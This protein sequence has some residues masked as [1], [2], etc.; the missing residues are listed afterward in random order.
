MN[1]T[2]RADCHKLPDLNPIEHIWANL[3]RAIR[4]HTTREN[5]L[6]L[7]IAMSIQGLFSR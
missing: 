7:A 6:S 1:V 4:N 5:N 3:K 2:H